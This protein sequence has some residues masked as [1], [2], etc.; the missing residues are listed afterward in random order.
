MKSPM[1][2]NCASVFECV[3]C[4]RAIARYPALEPGEP[5]LCAACLM[6]PAWFTVAEIRALL[7]PNGVSPERVE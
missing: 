5:P 7:D 3:E 6:M 4:H 2:D 1:T